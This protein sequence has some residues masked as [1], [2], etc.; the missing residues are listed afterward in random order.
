MVAEN[1]QRAKPCRACDIT[2]DGRGL[3]D[4]ARRLRDV[5]AT[6]EEKV[7]VS[8]EEERQ[9]AVNV[10]RADRRTQMGIGD[11]SYAQ[12]RRCLDAGRDSDL[13]PLQD[14]SVAAPVSSPVTQCQ[15]LR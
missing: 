3:G 2:K 7:G 11:E 5:V 10:R 8:S 14:G 12:P 9:S 13:N 4:V 1:R 15:R 6:E